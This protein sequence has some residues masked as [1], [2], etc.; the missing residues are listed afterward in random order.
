MA[1]TEERGRA[2]SPAPELDAQGLYNGFTALHDA[3][4]HGHLEAA[5]ALVDASARLNLTTHAGV[6]IA[7]G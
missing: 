1:L 6:A 2:D 5:R 3:V 4:W 7:I